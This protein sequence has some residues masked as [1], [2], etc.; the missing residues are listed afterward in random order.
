MKANTID[1]TKGIYYKVIIAFAIPVFFSNLFQQLYNS[2]DALIVGNF[3]GKNSL[4]AVSSSGNLIFLFTSFFVGTASGISVL[5]A[6]YFG[7]KNYDDLRKAIHTGIALGL[8]CAVILTILGVAFTP[9]MLKI[10]KTD[11][12]VLPESIK[13][14]RY[15]FLGISGTVMYNI[16]NGILNALGNSKRSLYYLIFSSLLNI[17]LD[18]LFI[19]VFK[20]GVEGAAIATAIAQVTSA[21]LCLLFL[22]KK[23]TIYQVNLNEIKFDKKMLRLILKY[24]VPAGVQNSVIALANVFVQS[25]INT[26]GNDAM[27]GCGTYSKLEG[28]AFLPVTCFTMALTTFVGQNLGAKQYERAKKGATFGVVCSLLLAEVIGVLM[29]LFMPYLARLFSDDINVINIASKQAKTIC[30]FYFLLAF[31]HCIAA[32]CRGAGKAIVPMIVM[33]AIWCVLRVTYINI[34]MSIAHEI[35]LVFLAY[36][37]TWFISS[38]IYFI[39]YKC[40]DWVHGFEKKEL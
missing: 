40:S 5:I 37:L 3:L 2:V 21:I 1:M 26:F 28:F 19:G 18:L 9:F 23:G 25:N 29:F 15:F 22:I 13:Y 34:A 7:E 20:M 24:G 11:A 10:M 36:P 6:K 14:F 39:Y 4:A 12:E 30:L 17:V 35:R 38:I 31:S 33:L 8:V 16:F 32:I 27:A